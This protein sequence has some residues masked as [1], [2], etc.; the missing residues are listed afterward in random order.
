MSRSVSKMV[1]GVA[2]SVATGGLIGWLAL[3]AVR[4]RFASRAASPK[5][6]HGAGSPAETTTMTNDIAD[7]VPEHVFTDEEPTA[8]EAALRDALT[9]EE[10]AASD[11]APDETTWIGNTRTLVLHRAD[12]SFLPSEEHRQYFQSEDDA[13]A[14]GYRR[15]ANE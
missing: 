1:V 13:I 9:A 8:L 11:V 10:A 14:A 4:A 5:R 6:T 2:V 7:L 3:R 15:A 12:S